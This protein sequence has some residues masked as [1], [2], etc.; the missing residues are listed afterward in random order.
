[1]VGGI[2]SDTQS[3]RPG[4]WPGY[5]DAWCRGPWLN[6]RRGRGVGE[7]RRPR[8]A[9]VTAASGGLRHIL[10][11]PREPCRRGWPLVR[12]LGF[13]LRVGRADAGDEVF[14]G[15]DAE[16]AEDVPEVELD[17]LTLTCRRCR[18]ERS[19]ATAAGRR[20]AAGGRQRSPAGPVPVAPAGSR[21]GARRSRT[22]PRRRQPGG[23]PRWPDHRAAAPRPPGPTAARPVPAPP[24]APPGRFRPHRGGPG[25]SGRRSPGIASRSGADTLGNAPARGAHGRGRTDDALQIAPGRGQE[26][27]GGGGRDQLRA[28]GDRQLLVPRRIPPDRDFSCRWSSRAVPARDRYQRHER[29]AQPRAKTVAAPALAESRGADRWARW[30][31]TVA[32]AIAVV[33]PSRPRLPSRPGGRARRRPRAG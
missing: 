4:T 7:L 23:R 12:T 18:A 25:R 15:S 9:V 29:L 19:H 32:G 14:A 1:M 11:G 28:G 31:S 16:L 21:R 26:R 30:L 6:D 8:D 13:R 2:G 3:R 24:P 33:V 10:A 17:G 20:R 22:P 5:R 27:L